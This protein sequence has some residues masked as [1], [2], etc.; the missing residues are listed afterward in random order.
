MQWRNPLH[1]QNTW[2]VFTNVNDIK[3]KEDIKKIT[4]KGIKFVKCMWRTY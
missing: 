3:N 4:I 2:F 1:I